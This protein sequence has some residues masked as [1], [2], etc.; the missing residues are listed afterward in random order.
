MSDSR[1]LVAL[2]GQPNCGKSTVFNMLTG[3]YQHVA[4]YPGVTVEKKTGFFSHDKQNIEL[5]DLPGTYSLTSYSLEERVARDFLLHE[6][7]K[8]CINVID[9][10]TL[11]RSLYLTLQLIETDCP[12]VV[13]LNM[14]D[15][16]KKDGVTIDI[17]KLQESLGIP[18]VP[19]AARKGK[20]KDLLGKAIIKTATSQQSARQIDY[21]PLEDRLQLL[22]SWLEKENETL[23][24]P[25]RWLTIKILEKDN[26]AIEY[27]RS[28]IKKSDEFL[29]LADK[30]ALQYEE[31]FNTGVS[32]HI[33]TCRYK[34]A[35]EIVQNC[36]KQSFTSRQLTNAVDSVVCHK[37]FGPI[38]MV[39][40]IY[41]LYELSI[42]QGYNLTN[43]F[44]PF[45]AKLKDLVSWLS[46]NPGFI[47]DP[48]LRSL[49]IW[50]IDSI[51]SLLNYIPIFLILFSLIAILEDSGYMPRMAFILDHLLYRFGL[52]G[53]STLPLVLGGVYVG[54]CAVPAIMSTKAVPCNR[55]RIATIMT[56]PMLNCMAKVPLYVVLIKAFFPQSEALTM[57]FISTI[58]LIIALPGVKLLTL[59]LLKNEE[60]APFIMEMPEYNFPTITGVLRSALQKV[61]LFIKKIV[62]I[63]TAVAIV[64][65]VLLQ[66]PGINKESMENYNARAEQAQLAFMAVIDKSENKDKFMTLIEQSKGEDEIAKRRQVLTDLVNFATDFKNQKMYAG[67]KEASQQVEVDFKKRNQLFFD[68][69]QGRGKDFKQLGNALKNLIKVRKTIRMDM[70]KERIDKSFLG[71]IG[72]SM[73]PITKWA[74]FNWRINV[75]LLSAL[76]AKENTVATLGALYQ[77]EESDRQIT[78][79]DVSAAM[80]ETETGFTSLHAL[81]LILFMIIYPPCLATLITIKLQTGSYKF[82]FLSLSY[83]IILGTVIAMAVFT[84]GSAL[85]LTGEQAMI[86]FYI[87]ALLIA[88]AFGFIPNPSSAVSKEQIQTT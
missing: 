20:G 49:L 47:E 67:S 60:N 62:T 13:A 55:A 71:K 4:N 53:Q 84:I 87:I 73:E 37:I 7:P 2:A 36:Q 52:H 24:V 16:A 22:K 29:A 25:S 21:G 41:L 30:L 26:S 63:V 44:W 42:V 19:T 48:I 43:Y 75:A 64:V 51:N 77:G 40:V 32:Q 88:I 33:A 54:G 35:D 11:K 14:M 15:K 34:I 1:I 28:S 9:V 27:V 56:I 58:S 83:Q 85:H 76:A 68:I 5:V 39:G 79:Q 23:K 61:W 86:A 3:A 17:E 78:Q 80:K 81:A 74:G 18:V 6:Q 10:S 8:V 70:Q 72:K 82:L 69:T 12:I 46:P 31:E 38:C 65:F 50:I 45:L 59:T 57:F 66:F